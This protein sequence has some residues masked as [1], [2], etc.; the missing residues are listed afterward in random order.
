LYAA[1]HKLA[2]HA[3]S[4]SAAVNKRPLGHELTFACGTDEQ[5]QRRYQEDLALA[6]F[7]VLAAAVDYVADLDLHQLVGG[8]YSALAV[9]RLPPQTSG[10]PSPT[11]SAGSWTRTSIS[12]RRSTSPY[13]PGELCNG[14]HWSW[15]APVVASTS[16]DPLLR[17]TIAVLAAAYPAAGQL[18]N[19]L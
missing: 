5:S 15:S 10:E 18:S 1:I 2:A 14:P 13:W 7:D 17:K 16:R 3:I 8:I 4:C 19:P 11:R 9:T 6:G 12:A